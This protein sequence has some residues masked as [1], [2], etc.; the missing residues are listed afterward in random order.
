MI[1]ALVLVVSLAFLARFFLAYCR[2]LL[3][4]SY[5]LELSEQAHEVTG[6]EDRIVT[7]D[8][9]K[10]VLQLIWL[11]PEPGDDRLKIRAVRTYYALLNLLRATFRSLAPSIAAW[12]GRERANCAY[13][14]AVTLDRRIAYNRELMARHFANRL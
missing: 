7:G 5:Q 11:C 1:A 4:S 14:A 12:A 8:E 3:T 6:I 2:S 10:R 9:F 13:F